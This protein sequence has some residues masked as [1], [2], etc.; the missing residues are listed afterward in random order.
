MVLVPGDAGLLAAPLALAGSASKGVQ[1]EKHDILRKLPPLPWDFKPS[2]LGLPSP[3]DVFQE[4]NSK[5]REVISLPLRL[6]ESGEIPSPTQGLQGL[7][8]KR[9][10]EKIKRQVRSVPTPFEVFKDTLGKDIVTPREFARDLERGMEDGHVL[11]E[12]ANEAF[13]AQYPVTIQNMKQAQADLNAMR[14]VGVD[15]LQTIGK[16]TTKLAKAGA[17]VLDDFADGGL[18]GVIF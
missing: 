3:E 14:V 12:S 2:G 6:L 1:Q 18:L 11:A 16:A 9:P 15:F 10:L 13:M 5:V 7:E 4:I 8:N 17:K